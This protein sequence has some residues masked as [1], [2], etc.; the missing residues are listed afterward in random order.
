MLTR[1]LAVPAYAV[2]FLLAFFPLLDTALSVF[3]PNLGEVAW[4][5]GAAGLFSRALMTPL[6]GLLLAFAVALLLEHR[7]VLRGL[8]ILSGLT[9][10]VLLGTIVLFLLD[11]LQMR[12]QVQPHAKV[13]FDIASAVALGK[14]GLGI[15]VLG[16]F[17]AS[18]WKASARVHA[19]SSRMPR[20]KGDATGLLVRKEAATA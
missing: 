20:D 14:Y 11:A 2:A 4:R 7:K 6:L 12:S 18:G 8:S 13:A 10:A 5:F 3:P 15:L 17:A 9:S 16:A 1:L 19:P